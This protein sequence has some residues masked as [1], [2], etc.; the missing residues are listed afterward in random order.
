MIKE[1]QLEKMDLDWNSLGYKFRQTDVNYI[2]YWSAGQWDQ[3]RL[4]RENTITISLG[5][6]ALHYGQECFEG[7][8]A[9]SARDGRVLLF[10]PDQ[11]ALRMQASAR[12]ILMPEVPTEK[13]LDACKQV[14][15][16]N[17]RW[18]PPYGTGATFY[19]RPLLFGHGDN[20][21]AKPAQ[22]YI[23]AIFGCP[24]GPY[25][26]GGMKPIS[27]IVSRYDRAAPFGT[28][29][30]KVGGNY[31]GALRHRYEAQ[32]AGYA[33]CLYLDAQ[34][35]TYI[36]ELGG[37]NLF[38]ITKQNILVTPQSPSILPSI[39]RRSIVEL[40]ATYLGMT[41]EERPLAIAELENFVEVGACG[42]ASIITPV[43]SI[44]YEGKMHTFYGDGN[45]AG[46][47][48]RQLYELLTA[49]QR[50]DQKGPAGWVVEVN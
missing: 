25:F 45:E 36:D 5:S 28:G 10:R 50:G 32:Q 18:V 39:T 37:A 29:H 22:E 24:V 13:F 3:G 1:D 31:A 16:A 35:H 34:T 8:K 49:I 2:S 20:L 21:G 27:V 9:Q 11:N 30:I 42:T 44:F 48:T 4:I 17:L 40:A 38:A 23:F 47:I 43:G 41:V 15:S 33:D 12:G 26:N 14:V 19:L 6:T 46:P 7:L